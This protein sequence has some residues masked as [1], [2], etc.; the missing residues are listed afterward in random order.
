MFFAEFEVFLDFYYIFVGNLFYA[1]PYP[2]WRQ[3]PVVAPKGI[4]T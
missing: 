4:K 3:I 2:L 1:T